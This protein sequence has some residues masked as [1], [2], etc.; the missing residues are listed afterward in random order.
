MNIKVKTIG[1]TI[2]LFVSLTLIQACMTTTSPP[3]QIYYYTLDYDTPP[4]VNQID[5]LPCSIRVE[6]FS[7]SPPFNTQQM[8]YT[9]TGLQRNGY[10]YHQWIAA[11]GE[12][13]PYFIARDLRKTGG[14]KAVMPPDAALSTTHSLYGWVEEF[15]EQDSSQD[16]HASAIIHISLVANSN[17]DLANKIM[18]Q[19]RFNAVVACK[20]NTPN[21]LAQAMSEAVSEISQSITKEIYKCLL[22]VEPLK[23]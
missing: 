15:I 20:T 23:Y 16:W 10:P 5:Q 12:L 13:V 8:I 6:R 1:I 3:K 9:R 19:K 4:A 17:R 2:I 18:F 21:G 14:F 11:P 7:T 22:K